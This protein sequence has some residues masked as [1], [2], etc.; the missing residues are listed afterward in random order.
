MVEWG[1]LAKYWTFR[2]KTDW[3]KY[4]K[5]VRIAKKIF[6]DNKIQEI[7]SINKKLWNFIN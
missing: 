2:R 4:K 6:F 5:S 7:A 3:I 1:M